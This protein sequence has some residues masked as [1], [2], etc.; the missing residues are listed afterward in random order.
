[1][2]FAA[3]LPSEITGGW[4]VDGKRSLGH[5]VSSALAPKAHQVAEFFKRRKKFGVIDSGHELGISGQFLAGHRDPNILPEA[6]EFHDEREVA[7]D[8]MRYGHTV[9]GSGGS[10]E[11][12]PWFAELGTGEPPLGKNRGCDRPTGA[13][14]EKVAI[15]AA[16]EMEV[17]HPEDAPPKTCGSFIKVQ[18]PSLAE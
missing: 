8:R 5:K 10:G 17:I 9:N 15:L 3:K 13:G 16:F 4:R 14:D 12:L 11:G 1:M 18:Y 6:A 7:S 2:A